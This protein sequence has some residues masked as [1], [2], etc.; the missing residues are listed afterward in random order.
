MLEL[1][2]FR[3]ALAGVIL[4]SL[5]AAVVGCYIVTRRMVFISGGIT[6]AC[7][8]GLGLGYYLGVP[9]LAASAVFAAASALGVD[10]LSRRHVRADSAIAAIWA[11]GMAIGILFIFLTPGYVPELNSFLFGNVLTI[12]A[13]DIGLFAGFLA[14]V[15]IFYMLFYRRIV[16]ISF[17]PDFARTRRLPVTFI[18]TVM[19]VFV[20][21]AI[22]LSI[23]MAG[24]MLLMSMLSLPQMAAECFTRRYTPMLALSAA[25]A[26]AGGV[27]GLV[28][29]WYISV[30]ASAAIVLLLLL[31]YLLSLLLSHAVRRR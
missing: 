15:A 31:F 28:A 7:F 3:F 6:H 23:R 10:W 9:P 16:A 14:V 29:A 26:V 4:L 12:S 30:P 25:V 19:T 18:N 17:D 13:A 24:I 1:P 20:A 5:T 22:V 11:F 8:G 27:G 2:F 21:L